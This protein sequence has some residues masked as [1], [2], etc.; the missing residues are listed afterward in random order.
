MVL[1]TIPIKSGLGDVFFESRSARGLDFFFFFSG[2]AGLW[3]NWQ[4][5]DDKAVR[6]GNEEMCI[7]TIWCAEPT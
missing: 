1:I 4:E 3:R 5:Q 7:P 6:R 2:A